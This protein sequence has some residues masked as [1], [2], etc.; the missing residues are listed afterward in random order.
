MESNMEKKRVKAPSVSVRVLIPCMPPHHRN[1]YTPK[2]PPTFFH[3]RPYFTNYAL[4]HPHSPHFSRQLHT[5]NSVTIPLTIAPPPTTYFLTTSSIT[6]CKIQTPSIPSTKRRPQCALR[7][8]AGPN[9]RSIS[10]CQRT[11]IW[12]LTRRGEVSRRWKT[13]CS[14]L[15]WTWRSL[16]PAP[17]LALVTLLSTMPAAGR[18]TERKAAGEAYLDRGIGI[19][20]LLIV[21]VFR[22]MMVA[23][24]LRKLCL[25]ISSLS[26]GISILSA[27]KG[28]LSLT[29]Q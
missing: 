29:F 21:R 6:K 26:C 2:S 22:S 11:W 1:D 13:I 8:T 10:G 5:Q 9:R 20:I 18:T 27:P 7:S 4:T 24:K 16:A 17:D 3:F 19:A 28:T 23:L 12:H 25:Q 15:T 14:R